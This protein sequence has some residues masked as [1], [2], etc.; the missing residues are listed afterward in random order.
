MKLE[1]VNTSRSASIAAIALL[2][3]LSSGMTQASEL[4]LSQPF[5]LE[6]DAG[7][8]A[9]QTVAAPQGTWDLR[10]FDSVL[11]PVTNHSDTRALVRVLVR[12][13]GGSNLFDTCQSAVLVGPGET[14]QV[15][16]RLI[17]RPQDPGYDP[18]K[19]FMM[20]FKS[21]RVRDN[22]IDAAAVA[23]LTVVLEESSKAQKVLIGTATAKLVS[24]SMPI[25]NPA[26]FPF[27]DQYGQ[28]VHS[29]W[30][31]KIFSDG[32]FE[33]LRKEEAD[34]T[35]AHPAPAGWNKYGGWA[36]G[37]TLTATG[38]FY[39][40][41]HQGKWWLVD[42][43]GKLFWSNGPTGVGFGG[44]LTPITDRENWFVSLPD[45]QG[46][47]GKFYQAGKFATYMYYKDRSWLG[48]DVAAANLVRKYGTEY[49]PVV[50]ELSH[51]RVRSWGFNTLGGWSAPEVIRLKKTP[52]TVSIHYDAP[53]IHY[54]MADVYHPTWKP[55][56]QRAIE[57]HAN[58]TA[59]DPWNIGYFVDNERWWGWRPRGACIGEE[60][61]KNPAETP[62]KQEFIKLL[63][64]KYPDIGALNAAWGTQHESW[65]A[66]LAHRAVPD[67]KNEKVLADCGD[68][69]MQFTEYYLRN[70]R[71]AV[72]RVAPKTMYLGP[73]FH[74]HVDKAIVE[75]CSKFADVV[76]YNIYDN[77]PTG[78]VNQYNSLD[79]PIMITE[80]GVGSDQQQ[81]PFRGTD[82]EETR[83]ALISKFLNAAI[84][85]PN[86]VGAHFFQYR[87]QPISGRPD[88]EGTLRGFVNITDT[89]NFNLVQ[90]NRRFADE[91]YPARA[92]VS[93]GPD[94]R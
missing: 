8:A 89:P 85:H 10:E 1:F 57:Q 29:D 77:P 70:V 93:G 74:G 15:R 23:S 20:Y 27:V 53:L 31:G 76:S 6:S 22:T 36:D 62:A 69:G 84:K 40:T 66:L 32:D 82:A 3:V 19:P 58:T 65:D 7:K 50:A 54:R 59:N 83:T 16:V 5:M 81:T 63:K 37:P 26:F 35:A 60:T 67:M 18:F 11:V 30:P 64:S 72:K 17:R 52:Y 94:G 9:R 55:A 87:D 48:Y 44:D 2:T 47:F 28:Y 38:N 90:T 49:K 46:E 41:K 61:L 39:A 12:N 42:P 4:V 34:E 24:G 13:D 45:R 25:E 88:G 51:S 68:F 33:E 86:I 43:D 14:K 91:M 92:K 80:W 56:M 21:I 79:V 71:D 73:R 78:R 75:L